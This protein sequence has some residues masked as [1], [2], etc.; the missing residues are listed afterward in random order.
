LINRACVH[1][2]WR[3][4][5]LGRGCSAVK[6]CKARVIEEEQGHY[7]HHLQRAAKTREITL[8]MSKQEVLSLAVEA[9]RDEADGLY[10]LARRVQPRLAVAHAHALNGA[11]QILSNLE[12]SEADDHKGRS[13]ATLLAQAARSDVTA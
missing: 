12:L 1:A 10:E 11:L 13:V 6:F 9:I 4:Y 8:A 3:P 7:G 5:S 2:K